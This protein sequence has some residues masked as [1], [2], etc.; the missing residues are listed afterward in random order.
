MRSYYI[1]P[2]VRFFFASTYPI[3]SLLLLLEIVTTCIA[4]IYPYEG[5]DVNMH[6]EFLIHCMR[7]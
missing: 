5:V 3:L 2:S 4:E 1:V 6:F 7:F